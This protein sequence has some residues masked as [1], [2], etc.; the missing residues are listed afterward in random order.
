MLFGCRLMVKKLAKQLFYKK[1]AS[2][3]LLLAKI[4]I[5]L[6]SFIQISGFK[7]PA[8]TFLKEDKEERI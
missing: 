6:M 5:H 8:G 3:R 2:A 1:R 7:K 4:R